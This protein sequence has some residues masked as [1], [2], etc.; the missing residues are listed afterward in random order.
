MTFLR[1]PEVLVQGK[2]EAESGW[3]HNR[4]P[5]RI[6]ELVNRLQDKRPSVEPPL[7]SRMIHSDALT[8]CVRTVIADIRVSAVHAG[9]RVD[10]E[11]GSP[12]RNA[13]YLPS[14]SHG[15]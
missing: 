8:R 15:I 4:I 2:V 1:N 7:G 6:A 11:P 5:A 12:C 14:A 9:K 13:S 3:T 10:R